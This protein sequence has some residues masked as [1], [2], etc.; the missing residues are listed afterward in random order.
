MNNKFCRSGSALLFLFISVFSYAGNIV[1]NNNSSAKVIVFGNTKIII[2]LDYNGK[3]NISGLNINGQSVISGP[4][5]IYSSIKTTANTYSTLKLTSAP[6]VKTG[7]NSVSVSNIKYGSYEDQVI[8]NW[9]FIITDTDIRFDIER[10]FPK[11]LSIE[12]AA[13]PSFNFDNIKT[14]DGAFLGYGGLAWFYLFNQKLCTYGV[15]TDCSTFWNSTTGNALKVSVSAKG[16]KVAMKY[17][18]SNEDKLIYNISVSDSELTSR[19]ETEK[20]S[21]FIRGKTDVWDT[22]AVPAGKYIQTISLTYINYNEAYNRGKF[23]GENGKQVTS[24]LNTI[25]RIGVIDEKHFGANSWHTPY[26]PICLHEQYIAQLAIGINDEN[27]TQGY[28]QCLD[29][30]R[31]NAV[32]SDGRVLARWAYLNEDAMPG[33]VTN[34][35]FYEAQWGYL[36]DSNPDFVANVAELYNLTGD[37]NWVSGHKKSCEKALDYMLRRDSNGNHLVEMMT[38]SE[39]EKRGSDWIDIIWASFENAFINAKLYH[40]LTVWA[41]VENKLNDP[42]KATYYSSFAEKL[43][44]SFNKTV[45]DGGF[46]NNK[47]K[48]YIHWLDKDKSAHGDNLVVPVNLMAIVYGLCD[49][50]VRR[51]AVLDKIEEQ[52]HRENLFFWPICLYPYAVGEGNDWQFPFPAYENGDIFLSWGSIGVEAFAD[53]KP[54][55]ALKYVDNVL[56][57]YENDGLAF[58]RYSRINQ[59]GLG[60]DILSGNS[61]AL[62]GL[63]KA[64]YGINPLYNRLYLNPH[65]PAKLSGTELIYNFRQNKLKIGLTANNYFISDKQFK[66]SSKRDFG[67]FSSQNEV[68]YFKEKNDLYS[69]KAQSAENISLEIVKWDAD[70]YNWIQSSENEHGKVSYTIRVT[71]TGSFYFIHNGDTIITSKSDKDGMLKFSVNSGSKTISVTKKP[72]VS[73]LKDFKNN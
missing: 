20:R 60:D 43:K 23:V 33:T 39:S 68:V 17:S 13:F 6:T 29:F 5:G 11:P 63:Y 66:I 73:Q 1:I 31:D 40:A 4:A 8:E 65:L 54:D 10:A 14:W 34:K 16:K 55:L 58:Q 48:W 45:E 61:L 9:N 49:D 28:K 42:Q 71:G 56:S 32:Q 21:R 41:E 69:L 2:T 57:R 12:E 15:H 37:I 35:G 51:N 53:Y 44:V 25:A 52:T 50:T 64:I 7:T 27:Y 19:H 59:K 3:C 46:W 70:E 72:D 36:M 30:Y 24:L 47:N 67:F 62:V 22:Y 26:G 38:D 18:R